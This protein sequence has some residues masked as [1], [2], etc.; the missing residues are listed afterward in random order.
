LCARQIKVKSNFFR[1][2]A[3]TLKQKVKKEKITG[4]Y[5][6]LPQSRKAETGSRGSTEVIRLP[7]EIHFKPAPLPKEAAL[8]FPSPLSP[9][10]C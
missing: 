1:E 10:T 7:F 2:A 5:A 3:K 9:H 4:F 8:L 6:P